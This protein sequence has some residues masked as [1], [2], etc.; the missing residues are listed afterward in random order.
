MIWNRERI[1]R[2]ATVDRSA[3]HAGGAFRRQPARRAIGVL[4]AA[5]ACLVGP[6][7]APAGGVTI[8]NFSDTAG[9]LLSNGLRQSTVGTQTASDGPGVH[10][11]LGGARRLTLTASG[12][13]MAG[14]DAITVRIV[15]QGTSLS[16]D[17]SVGAVGQL[18]VDYNAGGAG[19]A[20]D[21]ST[22]TGLA[23]DFA[24]VDPSAPPCVV[25]LILADNSKSVTATQQVTSA[26][27]QTVVFRLT[28]FRGV[29]LR[30][31]RSIS[32]TLAPSRAGDLQL[33]G[34]RTF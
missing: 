20:V 28:S 8:D 33:G 5:L 14:V 19:L 7:T 23:L 13:D 15:R 18:R 17:S 34:I 10:G 31:L 24:V 25:S 1:A 12:L 22:S 16:Y 29:N 32:V 26:G 6:A 11:V 2:H 30:K 4:V 3:S 27:K 9:V 21:L